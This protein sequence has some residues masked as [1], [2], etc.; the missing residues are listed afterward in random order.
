MCD[1]VDNIDRGGNVSGDLGRLSKRLHEVQQHVDKIDHRDGG[2]S[3]GDPHEKYHVGIYD[4]TEDDLSKHL[5]DWK[6]VGAIVIENR[7]DRKP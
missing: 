3:A 1:G 6:C 4:N 7:F 2:G 5:G